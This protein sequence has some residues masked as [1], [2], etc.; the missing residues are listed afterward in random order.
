MSISHSV[1]GVLRGIH[2]STYSKLVT[3]I[4]GSVY[5]VLVDLRRNSPT[6]RRWCAVI[7]SSAN[8]KQLF[9][10]EGCGHGFLCLKDA[11]ILYLQGGCFNPKFEIDISPFD[12]SLNIYWPKLVDLATYLMSDKDRC[13]PKLLDHE[14]FKCTA[15][16]GRPLKRILV[17]GASGQVG[18]ALVEAFG[19]ENVIGTYSQYARDFM[20][21]FD[22]EAAAKDPEYAKSIITLCRPEI[23]CICAGRTWVDGCENEGDLPF[24]VNGDA[25]RMLAR[26]TRACGGRTVFYSTDYVF[27]GRNEGHDYFETDLARPLNVYGSSKRAGE[28]AVMEEDP[29]AL[30]I[31]T[32]GVYGP[33]VQ[34]KNFVYQLCRSLSRG[35]KIDCATD[36]YACPTYNRDL[37]ALT[38]ALLESGVSGIF[39]CVGQS[40]L[41][42]YDFAM[43]I[44]EL[45]GFDSSYLQKKTSQ[46]IFSNTLEKLGYAA[47]RG[48]FFGLSNSKLEGVLYAK[49]RPRVIEEALLHWKMNPMEDGHIVGK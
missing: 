13:A 38:I 4:N 14:E 28:I 30:V 31:R 8:R 27:D 48:R 25:P 1:R 49:F 35:C 18:G 34:G 40:Y 11:D 32:S 21:H 33:E 12:P 47:T 20:V 43:R 46:E 9:I 17:I 23:V 5:D 41:S 36:A 15:D 7:L 37:A 42:R 29:N 39:H 10:P 44:A 45:W 26:Y 16:P 2:R 3:A 6:Y 24:L 22:L 19:S